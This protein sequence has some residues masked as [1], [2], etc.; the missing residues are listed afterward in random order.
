[1]SQVTPEEVRRDSRDSV[2]FQFRQQKS[3]P[4]L[5]RE[6]RHHIDRISLLDLDLIFIMV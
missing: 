3:H 1:M 6:D 5:S 4:M 2:P